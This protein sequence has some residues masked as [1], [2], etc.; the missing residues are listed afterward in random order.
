MEKVAIIEMNENNIKLLILN[1][2]AGGF[3]NVFDKIVE[4]VKL[5]SSIASE[6][7][8]PSA[9]VNETLTV[10]KLFRKV[11]DTNKVEK[12]FA[13]ATSFVKEAK[14]QKSFFDE[15]Y[16]NTSFSFTILS[17][18]EEIKTIY[19][20]V[21]NY[22][23]VPKG[24]L[25]DIEPTRTYLVHYNRRTILT[26]HT[27]DIGSSTLADMFINMPQSAE[28]TKRMEQ[29]FVEKLM[30]IEFLK[31][32]DPET[33]FV[34][35]GANILSIAKLAKRASHYPLEIDNNYVLKKEVFDAVLSK[36]ESL[37]IDKVSKLKGI[38]EER[39]DTLLGAMCILKALISYKNLQ[40][41]SVSSNGIE[42]GLI[43]NYVVPEIN[44]KPLSDMLTYALDNIRLF[45]DKELSNTQNV[46][47]LA[48][49][50]FKQL[51]VMHKLPRSYVKAL[52]IASSM[53]DCGTRVGFENHPA[54]SFEIIVNSKLNGIGHRDLLL[55]G[56]ACKLQNQDNIS[57]AEWVKYKDIL[58]EE[59][60]D[61]VRKLGVIIN[62]AASLDRSRTANV[63]DV[64]CDILGD[65]IIMKTIVKEDATF[66]IRQG[67]KIGPDFKRIFKKYLQI[68]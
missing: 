33:L 32:L 54:Y 57:L 62:L 7:L 65:S 12:V 42:D 23:D 56:F 39:A 16:N 48:I 45:Y 24:V 35:A 67:M 13:I 1:V 15:I 18:E 64:C 29:T 47:N 59:D 4:N 2:K 51:K 68:I 43:Y 66:D 3:Y 46:Y 58:T 5:G 10:L 30:E 37:D 22:I 25:I 20:G 9:K 49:I 17:M 52:R 26:I 38:S 6:G 53:Y 28:K 27:I 11:C 19:S 55:A 63:M 44:E 41:L 61:A 34:G 8:I 21:I 36:V 60:L 14:N 31:T 50:L 40:S